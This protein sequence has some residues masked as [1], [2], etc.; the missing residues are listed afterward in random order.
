MAGFRNQF[1]HL[2]KWIS[3]ISSNR[4]LTL[5][6]QQKLILPVY[7]LV[8]DHQVPHIKNLYQI[9]DTK[10]FVSDLDFLLKNYDPIDLNTLSD[11]V[12]G[13][14]TLRKKSF[15]IT[16]DDG[17][18]EFADIVAPILLKRGIPAVCFLNNN[19]ID[20]QALF[21][22]YKASIIIEYLSKNIEPQALQGVYD[23]FPTEEPSRLN[24]I[25]NILAIT[26]LNRQRVDEIAKPLGIDFDQYLK[27][28]RPYLTSDE[29]DSLLAQGFDF[30]AHSL[31]HPEYYLITI[32]E[33]L[34]QTTQ[35]V[36]RLSTRFALPHKVFAFPFTDYNVSTAFFRRLNEGYPNIGLTFG[37]AGLK[38]DPV[39]NH[40]Q[41]IP[42][43]MGSLS[44][45]Q[46]IN[47]ELLYYLLKIP[48]RKNTVD[49]K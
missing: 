30:G 9:R 39:Q 7:H 2:I 47:G 42:M 8:A 4:L 11:C 34:R 20:N 46:I 24:L 45:K 17:L 25:K 32:S 36:D 48:F 1:I 35:S 26:Y 3:P 37:S 31:D 12:H 6:T 5:L 29:I 27:D 40:L 41:R 14:I 23:L 15:L 22:R 18:R 21:Y 19:F 44:A 16:F 33:Q 28:K 10:T 13:K 38:Q 43:E 49:R